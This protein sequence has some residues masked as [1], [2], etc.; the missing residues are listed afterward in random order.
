MIH[1]LSGTIIDVDNNLLLVENNGIGYEI[2]V[3]H[4]QSYHKR[5]NIQLFVYPHITSEQYQLYGFGTREEKKWFKRLINISGIGPKTALNILSSGLDRLLRAI[6]EKNKGFFESVSGIGKKTALKI[7]IELVEVPTDL[8]PTLGG[9]SA[10]QEAFTTLSRLGYESHIIQELL[11][12]SST[13]ASAGELVT[14]AIKKH[15]QKS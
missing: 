2:F 15:A 12:N 11:K 4:N 1:Y 14:L 9:N 7:M 3:P 5:G 6:T 13:K 10:Y 8:A